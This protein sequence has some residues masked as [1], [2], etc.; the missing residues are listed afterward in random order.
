M[1]QI[2][3]FGN[4]LQTIHLSRPKPLMSYTAPAVRIVRNVTRGWEAPRTRSL[5]GYAT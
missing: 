4:L 1:A 2:R 5:E 3:L